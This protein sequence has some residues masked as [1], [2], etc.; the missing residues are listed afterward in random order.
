MLPKTNWFELRKMKSDSRGA[1]W[2]K[3][4][5]EVFQHLP[6]AQLVLLLL[7]AVGIQ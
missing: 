4:V 5:V 2:E 7:K 3:P 6:T 1:T